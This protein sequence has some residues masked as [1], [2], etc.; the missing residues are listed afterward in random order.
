MIVADLL[1]HEFGNRFPICT[2]H[3]RRH[4]EGRARKVEI[5]KTYA[6]LDGLAGKRVLLVDDVVKSGSTLQCV[7]NTPVVDHGVTESDICVAVLGIP[8]SVV[9]YEP[10][11]YAFE[12]DYGRRRPKLPWGWIYKR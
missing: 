4:T 9:V 11:V 6:N 10:D 2:I 5:D 8:D 12:F 7:V 1:N 3:T